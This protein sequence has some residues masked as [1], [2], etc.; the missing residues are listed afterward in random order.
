MVEHLKYVV[1]AEVLTPLFGS[2]VAG[3]FH[4]CV[5]ERGAY[6]FSIAL[7]TVSLA[8]AILAFKWIIFDGAHFNGPLYTWMVSGRFHFDIGFLL[9]RLSACMMLLVC[10][11]SWL[12]HIYSVGYMEGDPGRA[13]FF[14]YV[15]LFTFMM[16]MLVSANDFLQLFF[17]WE[18]VGLVSYLLISFWFKKDS[19]THGGMKAFLANRVGDMGFI[20]GIA[21][22]LV[23][24]GSLDYGTVFSH[25]H[26][27]VTT[28]YTLFSGHPWTAVSIACILLFVGAMGKSS[29][30]PLHVWLPE[31]MQ[32]PTPISA[33][34]HAATMVT[35]GVYMVARLSPLFELSQPALSLVL[36][37]GASGAFFLGVLAFVNNDLKRIIAY[38]TMSQLGYMMAANGASAFQAGIFHLLTHGCFKA[39]LF[40]SAGAVLIVMKDEHD[41]RKMGGLRKYMPI[42][43]WTFLIG[44]LSLSAIPP[45]AGFYSKDSIIDAVGLSTIPGAHYAYICVLLGSFVTAFYI[46]REFFL[47]FHGKERMD[48]ATRNQLKEAPRTM[49]FAQVML[50]IPAVILGGCLID[51]ILYT[52]P[53]LLGS[54]IVVLPK[55]NVL[56][57]LGKEYHGVWWFWGYAFTTWAFW[58]AIMGIVSAWALTIQWPQWADWLERRLKLVYF[59]LKEQYGF[60][61]FNDFF[62][63]RGTIHLSQALFRYIDEKLINTWIVKG[64]GTDVLWTSRLVKRLQTGY[65]YHYLFVIMLSV[66]GF[67]LWMFL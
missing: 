21:I 28:K 36:V 9:D 39:L 4:K 43:Y 8:C 3:I 57:E 49:L 44:A 14:S 33:L 12:V 15:S 59:I 24:V 56:A 47:V 55:Y 18:G 41:I 48:D 60:D 11:V 66:L 50:S 45:F 38:S 53:G 63:V 58:L 51:S 67:L 31:S 46:F 34:I 2:F 22:I 40:L 10:F 13:R 27:M 20:L 32:G 7:M 37:I 5:G 30:I 35:A 1:L 62:L 17:G 52:H 6:R 64:V 61:R 25:A 54:S 42:T 29:Q 16:L 26:E 65:L 19:A 23:T